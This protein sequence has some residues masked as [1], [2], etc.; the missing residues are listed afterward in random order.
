[1]ELERQTEAIRT[2]LAEIRRELATVVV[3][4]EE[5]VESLLLAVLAGGHVLLEGLPGLGKTLMVKS[6]RDVLGL[7]YG[8]IQFTPDLMP[9]DITGTHII[10]HVPGEEKSFRFEPG[11]VFTNLLL[12]DE[13]NRASPKTQSALL[14]AMQEREVTILGRTYPIREPFHVVATQNP[15]EMAGTYPLPEAQLD[16]FMFKVIVPTPGSADLVTIAE[17]T[18]G[19]DERRARQVIGPGRLLEIRA[20]AREIPVARPVM[21]Y[22]ARLVL[23]GQP[24]PG[25]PE[26]TRRYVRYG[27]SPR[28]LQALVAAAKVSALLDG[29][30]NVSR[31]DIRGH[32]RPALRHRIILNFEGDL[33]K[34]SVDALLDEL[35]GTVPAQG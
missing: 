11:P 35:A 1:M 18:T 25:A 10:E 7:G 23:A 20:I 26:P 30:F 27:P 9:A 8:R 31:E 6:L 12:A 19:G 33:G 15:I 34:V 17:R 22:A 14:Q 5:V 3:G 21:E 13:I 2:E 4:Q 28:G 32:L 24:G 16:R 29:R